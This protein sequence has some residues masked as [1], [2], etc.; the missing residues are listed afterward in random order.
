MD[1]CAVTSGFLIEKTFARMCRECLAGI[2]YGWPHLLNKGGYSVPRRDVPPEQ[3]AK[4]YR[5]VHREPIQ[6]W[7]EMLRG[8]GVV[9]PTDQELAARLFLDEL[10]EAG[11][12]HDD[13]IFAL[14]DA[15]AL[16][17]KIMPP[18]EREIIWAR[19]MDANDPPPPETVLLGY[20]PSAFYPPEC[21]SAVAEGLFFSC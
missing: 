14:A 21:N 20:E 12:A 13:F 3:M 7:I 11:K 19:R 6:A 2:E 4:Q 16:L 5:G 1:E 17:A 15:R 9:E 10:T 18:I 8:S